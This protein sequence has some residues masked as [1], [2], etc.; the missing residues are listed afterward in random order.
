MP[1]CCRRPLLLFQSNF[2]DDLRDY[3]DTF[4]MLLPWRFRAVWFT[5]SGYPGLIPTDGFGSWV[6]ELEATPGHYWSAYDTAT[7][8]MVDAALAVDGAITALAARATADP[9]STDPRISTMSLTDVEFAAAFRQ[10][11]IEVQP[12]L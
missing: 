8:P 6:Q 7:T 5:S 12:W 9:D 4:A 1:G 2:D 3:I 10:L 11:L